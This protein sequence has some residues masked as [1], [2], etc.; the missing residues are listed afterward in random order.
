M[1]MQPLC[2]PFVVLIF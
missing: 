2:I 1:L